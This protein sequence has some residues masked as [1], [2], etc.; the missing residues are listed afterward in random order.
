MAGLPI[1]AYQGACDQSLTC[2][3]EICSLQLGGARD[4]WTVQITILRS[5]DWNALLPEVP[6][7]GEEEPPPD[8]NP[9][10]FMVLISM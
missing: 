8:G 2:F 5:N 4:C 1:H 9:H 6:P 7:A 3:E 10:P